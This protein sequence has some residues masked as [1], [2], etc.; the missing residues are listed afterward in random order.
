MVYIPSS[1]YYGIEAIQG[2]LGPKSGGSRISSTSRVLRPRPGSLP[3]GGFRR[4]RVSVDSVRFRVHPASGGP[5]ANLPS[6]T[7]RKCLCRTPDSGRMWGELSTALLVGLALI[8]YAIAGY[9]TILIFL[10][11][12]MTRGGPKPF[13]KGSLRNPVDLPVVSLVIP[14]R[15]EEIVIEGALRCAD[16]LQYPGELKEVLLVE[17]GS[18]DATPTIGQRMAAVLP[19]VRCLSGG[20]SR[21]K[22]PALNRAM[23]TPAETSS[24]SSIPTRD[25]SRTSSSGSR[26]TSTTTRT[27]AWSRL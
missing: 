26:S 11:L 18:R 19:N 20:P 24:A 15:D 12:R 2:P 13:D 6:S 10:G 1:L 7:A 9:H 27:S 14:A 17:D 16:R 4:R 5:R 22:P 21:G 23:A 3:S 8:F 25:T